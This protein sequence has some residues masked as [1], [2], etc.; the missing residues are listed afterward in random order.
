MG[1]ISY[2]WKHCPVMVWPQ[3]PGEALPGFLT[4][5]Y[6]ETNAQYL[7]NLFSLDP[8]KPMLLPPSNC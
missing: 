7:I 3:N 5:R 1:L 8:T 2:L 4:Q 6:R